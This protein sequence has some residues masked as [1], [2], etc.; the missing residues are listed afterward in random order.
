MISF[1]LSLVA[2]LFGYLI[3]GRF[4]EKQF[5]PDDRP[6]PA[7]AKAD[8]V[9][10]VVLPNWKIFMI[11]FLNIAGTGPIFGA[12]MGAKFGPAAYLWIVLGCIFAGATHDYLSGM[13]SVRHGGANQPEIIGAYLGNTTKKV[14][15][16][17]SVFLL[18]MVGVVFVYS[19]AKILG[20]MTGADIAAAHQGE[21]QM[22]YVIWSVIIF[23]YYIIATLMPVDKIIGKIYP[24]FAFS[25]LFMAAALLVMLLVKMPDIPEIWEGL[26][27]ASLEKRDIFPALFITIACGAISGFHATQSPLMARCIKNEHMGRPIFYG[28]MIT[29]GVV[30]LIWATVAMYFF[31]SEPTP[32]YEAIAGGK[33]AI[34]DAPTIV[35]LVCNEWL[36]VF[37]AVLALLGVVAAP[38]TSGDTALRSC[39]LI[40]ADFLHL[41]QHSIRNRLMVCIPMFGVAIALLLWQMTDKEGFNT[42]WGW[43]GW[44]NQTLSVFMLWALTV[45]MVR[46]KK[47]YVMTLLPALFMTV[48][49]T[50]FLADKL[51][52]NSVDNALVATVTLMV[53]LAWFVVWFRREKA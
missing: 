34:S 23:A 53:S 43:F 6:T 50:T 11:Q 27:G 19:P 1:C 2:L 45:Y 8:G 48:V 16:V 12:I 33:T 13:L 21:M 40:I 5:A 22:E 37:G 17:F 25:L 52:G 28:S 39:R 10:F 46:V 18:L 7:V 49:C 42:I 44:S 30:A 31:Y 51:F 20:D 3:Y 24:L 15:L 4:V 36:G 38:I 47:L 29:E 26:K 9:D 32:G 41:E 14:M 35:N